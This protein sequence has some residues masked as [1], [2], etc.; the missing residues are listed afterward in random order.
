LKIF[1]INLMQIFQ[2]RAVVV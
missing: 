1:N 2:V